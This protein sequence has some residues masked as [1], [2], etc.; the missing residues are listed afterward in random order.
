M[1]R[2]EIMRSTAIGVLGMAYAITLLISV[3]SYFRLRD[4]LRGLAEWGQRHKAELIAIPG[5][6]GTGY[7][8]THGIEL[9]VAEHRLLGIALLGHLMITGCLLIVVGRKMH[10]KSNREQ[11]IMLEGIP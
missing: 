11:N 8:P 1:K 3:A 5:K 2:S 9:K 4:D 6:G 10:Q 7:D